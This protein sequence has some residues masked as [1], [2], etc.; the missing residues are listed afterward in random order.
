MSKKKEYENIFAKIANIHN[1][2]IV[3]I[4]KNLE[5]PSIKVRNRRMLQVIISLENPEDQTCISS[6][7]LGEYLVTNSFILTLLN[8]QELNNCYELLK[9]KNTANWIIGTNIVYSLVEN[10]KLELIEKNK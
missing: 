6:E 4:L 7:L 2:E 1:T 8:K 9:T 10:K 5:L 3:S